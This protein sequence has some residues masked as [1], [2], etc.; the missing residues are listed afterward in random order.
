MHLNLNTGLSKCL[1][2]RKRLN[3]QRKM[4][5]RGTPISKST[6]E[7]TYLFLSTSK[8]AQ[9]EYKRALSQSKDMMIFIINS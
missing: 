3:L 1:P 2:I 4:T 5:D 8:P 6:V 7:N 9:Y